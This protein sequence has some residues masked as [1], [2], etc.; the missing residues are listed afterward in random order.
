MTLLADRGLLRHDRVSVIL[1]P[2]GHLIR[3]HVPQPAATARILDG[4]RSKRAEPAAATNAT[5]TAKSTTQALIRISGWHFS[6]AD[7]AF[8]WVSIVSHTTVC[9]HR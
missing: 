2:Q 1:R 7:R 9:Q 6:A 5:F 8:S 4:I 3:P